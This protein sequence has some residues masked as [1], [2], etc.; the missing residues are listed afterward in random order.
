MNIDRWSKRYV[1][2]SLLLLGVFLISSTT[3]VRAQ[4][5]VF[6]QYFNSRIYSN[7]AFTGIDGALNFTANY[8][9]Q[10]G[11][12][13]GGFTTQYVSVEDFEPCFNSGLGMFLM[14]DTEG[15]GILRTQMVAVSYAY[16]IPFR[17][18]KTLH[19]V[20][21]G[22]SPYYMQKT[23]D[24]SRRIFSDQLD[25]KEG[26]IFPTQ[27]QPFDNL[28]VNFGGLNAG[29]VYRRD[30]PTKWKDDSQLSIGVA[31]NHLLNVSFNTGP[32]ESLQ[33][34]DTGLSPRISAF[35]GY[36]HPVFRMTNKRYIFYLTPQLRYEKQGQL[37]STSLGATIR[38]ETMT[39]GMFYQNS[40]PFA[41][42]QNTN[43]LVAYLGFSLGVA[44]DQALD[45]GLSYDTNAGGL[46]SR[47]GGV[48]EVSLKYYIDN[49]GLFCKL[50]DL[51]SGDSRVHCPPVGQPA[52]R[53]YRRSK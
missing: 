32:I 45:I 46:R 17:Q 15:E 18:G 22:I 42:W 52:K 14:Q 21:L 50:F 20:R 39:V 51:G 43:S 24:W 29:F 7:P 48:F 3:S 41:D 37:Q 28:P 19:N 34:L 5:P 33:G 35:L 16:V 31:V 11:K 44:D 25:P 8:R 13:P 49:N 26:A 10:W 2:G 38:Y 30:R 53:R 40:T 23:I 12:V 9:K 1:I 4:D 27:F 6:T 36:Y 47:T